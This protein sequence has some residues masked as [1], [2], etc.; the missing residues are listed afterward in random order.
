[1]SLVL[2]QLLLVLVLS[3]STAPSNGISSSSIILRR[4]SF[5]GP[6]LRVLPRPSFCSLLSPYSL[7]ILLSF[8]LI[9]SF[10]LPLSHLLRR[11]VIIMDIIRMPQFFARDTITATSERHKAISIIGVHVFRLIKVFILFDSFS[12]LIARVLL[13]NH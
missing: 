3:M 12:I 8:L 1:M 10:V 2:T 4:S 11:K 5:F 7:L 6:F 13:L 9:I